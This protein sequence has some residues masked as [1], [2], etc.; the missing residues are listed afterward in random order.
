MSDSYLKCFGVKEK[1]DGKGREIT[2]GRKN[3]LSGKGL[4]VM[5]VNI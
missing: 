3:E 1:M 4:Q 5:K 2:I